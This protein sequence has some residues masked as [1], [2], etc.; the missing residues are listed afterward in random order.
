MAKSLQKLN[1]VLR[2]A[3]AVDDFGIGK[4]PGK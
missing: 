1:D 2:I 3:Q 4:E